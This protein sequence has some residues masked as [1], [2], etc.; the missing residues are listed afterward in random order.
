MAVHFAVELKACLMKNLLK[1]S[2]RETKNLSK[3]CQ[4]KNAIN[5]TQ[6]Q[7]QKQDLLAQYWETNKQVKNSV[8][9]DKRNFSNELT[10]EAE[11]AAGKRD[12]KRLYEITRL[13]SGKNKIQSRPVK[14]KNGEIITDE[15]EERA[16]SFHDILNRPPPLTPPEIPPAEHPLDVNTSPPSKAEVIKA[17]KILKAGKAAGP[18]GVPPEALKVDVQTSTEMLHP[19]QM[20]IWRRGKYRRSGR[21]GIW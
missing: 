14:N 19:L 11:T 5:Q 4:L 2:K 12:M 15:K 8:R 21:K 6:D 16:R 7:Q 3:I 13:L 1:I 20:K 9:Q 17:I 10:E 18:D